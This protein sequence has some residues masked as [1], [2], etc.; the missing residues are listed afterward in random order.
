MSTRRARWS[1]ETENISRP[2][3]RYRVNKPIGPRAGVIYSWLFT[4]TQHTAGFTENSDYISLFL[5]DPFIYLFIYLFFKICKRRHAPENNVQ[6]VERY[7]VI[8]EEEEEEG[9]YDI[10]IPHDNESFTFSVDVFL[11]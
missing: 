1:T 11:R 7:S 6:Y 9:R 2:S 4:Y 5:F 3:G 8:K 10:S